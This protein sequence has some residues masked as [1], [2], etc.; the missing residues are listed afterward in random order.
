MACER[1]LG[2]GKGLVNLR[3]RMRVAD[4]P[5]AAFD[6][7]NPGFEQATAKVGPTRR[8]VAADVVAI[9]RD[10]AGSG[11]GLQHHRVEN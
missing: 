6:G 1:A 3:G 10:R 4:E 11:A 5:Q 9:L 8:V 2:A 7:A